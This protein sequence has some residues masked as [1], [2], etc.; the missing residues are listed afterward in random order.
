[1]TEEAG[2]L[3]SM[4]WQ[5]VGASLHMAHCRH[6][7]LSIVG[8]APAHCGAGVPTQPFPTR[9]SG[10]KGELQDIC[11]RHPVSKQNQTQHQGNEKG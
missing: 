11:V 8:G 2:M 3:Q 1:M 5:R 6:L 7:G 9:S 4:G 10:L